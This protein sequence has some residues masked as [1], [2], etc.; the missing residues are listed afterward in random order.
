[1]PPGTTTRSSARACR[2]PCRTHGRCTISSRRSP[3][4]QGLRRVRSRADGAPTRLRFAADL[5]AV[6]HAEDADNRDARRS[7]VSERMANMDPEVF[8]LIVGVF[9][10]PETIGEELLDPGCSIAFPPP[11]RHR[12]VVVAEPTKATRDIDGNLERVAADFHDLIGWASP[13]ELRRPDQRHEMDEQAAALPHAV[14]LCPGPSLARPGQGFRPAPRRRLSHVRRS[15]QRGH[16]PVP[17]R[18]LSHHTPRY[19]ALSH[20]VYGGRDGRR[21]GRRRRSLRGERGRAT[22]VG[23]SC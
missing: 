1:M 6:T 21:C 15:P 3:D 8:P 16:P 11:D 18:Q 2:S 4:D 5:I 10:G 23:R 13:A 14:R 7:Y 17:S 19:R 20:H 9:A 12:R 22:V